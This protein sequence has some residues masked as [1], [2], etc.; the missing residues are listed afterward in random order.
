MYLKATT[1]WK[2]GQLHQDDILSID[3]CPPNF[4][5]TSSF[6]G[7]IIV[8]NVKTEKIFVR[9]RKGRPTNM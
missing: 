1:D 6:D 2:G 8:W 9:L 4:V 5:A 3:F 7:E